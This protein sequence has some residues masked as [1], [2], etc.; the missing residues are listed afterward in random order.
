MFKKVCVGMLVLAAGGFFSFITVAFQGSQSSAGEN[1]LLVGAGVC[2]FVVVV[3]SVGW[4]AATLVERNRE[5]KQR[6]LQ[7]RLLVQQE[8]Q[9]ARQLADQQEQRAIQ[10]Q[11]N[12]DQRQGRLRM[13]QQNSDEARAMIAKLNADAAADAST[14]PERGKNEE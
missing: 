2:L 4:I 10:R 1:G 14:L 9:R 3:A 7:A 11:Q 8:E 6:E 13:T 12:E 5:R